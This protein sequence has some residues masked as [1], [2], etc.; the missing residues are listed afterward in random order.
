MHSR[1]PRFPNPLRPADLAGAAVPAGPANG[2]AAT[3]GD[4]PFLQRSGY[5]GALSPARR[6]N[7]RRLPMAGIPGAIGDPTT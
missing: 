5:V 1:D 3:S 2:K 4:H 6:R 7:R